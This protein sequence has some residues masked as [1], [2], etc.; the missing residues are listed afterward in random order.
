MLRVIQIMILCCKKISKK[1]KEKSANN[2]GNFFISPPNNNNLINNFCQLLQ[3]SS[4]KIR[5]ISGS[6]LRG[7]WSHSNSSLNKYYLH[8]LIFNFFFVLFLSVPLSP[9]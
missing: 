5:Y 3:P 7:F 4:H 2:K 9:K 8:L 1:K 6:I